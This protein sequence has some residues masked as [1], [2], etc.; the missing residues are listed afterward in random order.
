[1]QQ[2]LFNSTCHARCS[3]D[4]LV[5][6]PGLGVFHRAIASAA[7]SAGRLEH[8]H[9]PSAL[10]LFV[11]FTSCLRDLFC[12]FSASSHVHHEQNRLR[13][14]D[15]S[16]VPS[17]SSSRSQSLVSHVSICL[18]RPPLCRHP[19]AMEGSWKGLESLIA[20]YWTSHSEKGLVLGKGLYAVSYAV[21]SVTASQPRI[22][23]TLFTANTMDTAGT[24]D[25]MGIFE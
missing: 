20:G 9:T 14:R 7:R 18:L 10:L 25:T 15:A 4:G 3:R 19:A 8:F 23:S 11:S 12:I 17:S 1:M 21:V 2:H 16:H 24:V 13:P 6:R 5:K 22:F